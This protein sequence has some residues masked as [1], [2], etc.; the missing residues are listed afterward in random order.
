MKVFTSI[1]HSRLIKWCKTIYMVTDAQFGFRICCSTSI[2]NI[3]AIYP[4]GSFQERKK[5]VYIAASLTTSRHFT[6]YPDLTYS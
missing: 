1:I 5:H 2:A 6:P 4:E 3:N